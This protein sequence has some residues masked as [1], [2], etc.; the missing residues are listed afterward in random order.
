M[1]W[2]KK[3]SKNLLLIIVAIIVAT[4]LLIIG[5][6]LI[7]VHVKTVGTETTIDYTQCKD[8]YAPDYTCVVQVSKKRMPRCVCYTIITLSEPILGP[9]TVYYELPDYDQTRPEYVT[10]KDDEQLAGN[11]SSVISPNCGNN[12]YA[13]TE[14]KKPIAPCGEIADSMFKDQYTLFYNGSIVPSFNT[15]LNGITEEDKKKYRNPPNGDLQAAFKDF[16]KPKSWENKVTLLDPL[17]PNNNAFQNERFIAWMKTDMKRKPALRINQTGIFEDGLFAGSYKFRV[18]Y[19]PSN[20]ITGPRIAVI[21]SMHTVVNN[22]Q[23]ITGILLMLIDYLSRCSVSEPQ[24]DRSAASA[25]DS[26]EWHPTGGG[27]GACDDCTAY[28]NF[29]V[30]N[31]LPITLRELRQE[32]KKN[33]VIRSGLSTEFDNIPWDGDSNAEGLLHREKENFSIDVTAPGSD[34]EDDVIR[35]GGSQV[36]PQPL[37]VGP[38]GSSS[39]ITRRV[40]S[41]RPVTSPTPGE[42]DEERIMEADSGSQNEPAEEPTCEPAVQRNK[43]LSRMLLRKI[44]RIDYKGFL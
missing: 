12:S 20:Y 25:Y 6:V 29:V 35:E 5:L 4:S 16:E 39:M 27:E 11:L 18:I 34:S 43:S 44:P 14:G 17:D 10:S 32:I 1:A 42:S 8:E 9:V 28:V 15:G 38:A 19:L 3:I 26:C 30:D 21:S 22:G 23:L 31:S 36:K 41:A 2:D 33:N 37:T 40:D 13:D 7:L 24:V